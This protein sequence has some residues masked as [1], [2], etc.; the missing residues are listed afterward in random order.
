MSNLVTIEEKIKNIL[1]KEFVFVRDPIPAERALKFMHK[2][3]MSYISIKLF[4]QANQELEKITDILV[5]NQVPTKKIKPLYILT[6]HFEFGLQEEHEVTLREL[7]KI[8]IKVCL[9]QVFLK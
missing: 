2:S 9:T 1:A 8:Q 7:K 3:R 6:K 4:K 5:F